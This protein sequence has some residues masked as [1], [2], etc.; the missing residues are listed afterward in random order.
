MTPEEDPLESFDREAEEPPVADR[1]TQEPIVIDLDDG[2]RAWLAE[3]GYDPAYGA[4]PLKRVIQREVQD[5]LA[6]KIL[7]G[8]VRD[9]SVVKIT[10]GADRLGFYVV[11]S[12]AGVAGDRVAA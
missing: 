2:A 5:P 4:R 10:A 3:R 11:G 6:E 1:N 8:E 9:E 7:L 12:K